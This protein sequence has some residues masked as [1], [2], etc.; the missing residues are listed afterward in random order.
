MA[1]GFGS[2]YVGASGLQGSQNALNAT[3]HNLSN[4]N[5]AGYTR[6]Q[7]TFADK[8]SNTVGAAAISPQQAGLGVTLAEVRQVRDM[9]L[10]EYYRTESG[11][12][13]FYDTTFNAIHDVQVFYGEMEGNA[14]QDVL[15]EF[16][17][18]VQEY[19]KTPADTVKQNLLVQKAMM[20]VERSQSVMDGLKELQNN[21]N[22]QV[23]DTVDR[24]NTL[25][26]TINTLNEQIQKVEA[27]S[28]EAAN[29]L[30]DDRNR[31]LDE[32][33]SLI[34]MTYKERDSVVTVK[35]EGVDFVIGDRVFEMGKDVDDVTG[36]I[37][38]VWPQLEN[39]KRGIKTDVFD[40]GVDIAS[41]LDT[42][43]GKLKALV[44]ARGDK[45]ATYAD[46]EGMSQEK[47]N[48]TTGISMM[49]KV[50]AELDQFIHQ[51]VTTINDVLCPNKAVTVL[52]ESG[53][54]KKI[55]IWDAEKSSF[56]TNGFDVPPEELFSRG[57]TERYTKKVLDL[58]DEA[59][60]VTKQTVYVYNEEDTS[61]PRDLT[62][63]YTLDNLKINDNL[64]E[65][66]TKIAHL[67]YTGA[68]DFALGDRMT[69]AF[70]EKKLL[71]NPNS[72]GT[73]TFE[74]Y[75][76]KM[77]GEIGTVGS[78]FQ[79]ISGSIEAS[80]NSIEN[81]RQQ[82]VGVSSDEELSN[83]IRFQNA[84]NA[85]SRYMNVVDKMLEHLLTQLG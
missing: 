49:L 45:N 22:V 4:V 2:L 12:H 72:T 75:Y 38:P 57:G 20:F 82:V 55:Q 66:K 58:V 34:K 15:K 35:L 28:V 39:T 13:A 77:L 78:V 69:G 37:T 53:N 46:V 10:D 51:V 80:V 19:D 24:I 33:G 40:F 16:W 47:Y 23:R 65:D 76:E 8:E 42:D 48:D 54:P 43:I 52:D 71:L 11:R 1:T 83:M 29:D 18:S 60:N 44:L 59:G 14:Y 36:F 32:L 62:S 30:R 6:Q 70:E 61:K 56:S 85:A 3:A 74:E 5:R 64:R 9:F 67:T 79:G 25:G 50:E 63:M 21:L 17:E 41:D 84:Y 31:A 73:C 27:G 7:A 81:K 26:K 68:E